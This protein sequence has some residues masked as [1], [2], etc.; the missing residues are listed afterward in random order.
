L[1]GGVRVRFFGG[2]K[3]ALSGIGAVAAGPRGAADG[4]GD[5]LVVSLVDGET[6]LG[7]GEALPIGFGEPHAATPIPTTSAMLAA[8]MPVRILLTSS[9]GRPHMLSPG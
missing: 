6:V 9:P 1:N 2:V 7:A 3:K 5:G 4:V 8:A